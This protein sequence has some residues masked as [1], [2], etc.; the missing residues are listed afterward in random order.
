MTVLDQVTGAA[1]QVLDAD[2]PILVEFWAERC[3]SYRGCTLFWS[4]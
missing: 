4:G 1:F 3:G 2:L